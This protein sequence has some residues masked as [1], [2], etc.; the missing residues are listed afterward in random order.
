MH[1][2]IENF[3]I[4]IQYSTKFAPKGQITP[5]PYMALPLFAIRFAAYAGGIRDSL[6]QPRLF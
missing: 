1:F 5:T 2:L 6:I 4:L 3:C